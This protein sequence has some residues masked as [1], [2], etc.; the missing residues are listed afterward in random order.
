MKFFRHLRKADKIKRK[1]DLA[2]FL[3]HATDKEKKRV[4]TDVTKRA[5]ADQQQTSSSS[6]Q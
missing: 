4:F 6:S 2:D 1:Q 5:N 3:L